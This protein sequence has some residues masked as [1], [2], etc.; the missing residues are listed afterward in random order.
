MLPQIDDL[1]AGQRFALSVRAIKNTVTFDEEFAT[2]LEEATAGFVLRSLVQADEALAAGR[3]SVSVPEGIE[4]EVHAILDAE[5]MEGAE[6]LVMAVLNI[7]GYPET[8]MGT[9]HV[10]DLLSSCYQSILERQ[11]TDVDTPEGE[12]ANANCVRAI[13]EQKELVRSFSA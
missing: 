1:S 11:D 4:E 7:Y 12:R 13:Q 6:P 9:E 5:E 2:E 10:A 8:G 3:T